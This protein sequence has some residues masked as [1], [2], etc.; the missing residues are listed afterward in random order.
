MLSK[1]S[2]INRVMSDVL[3]TVAF[4][5][6]TSTSLTHTRISHHS[7]LPRRQAYNR[8]V[9]SLFTIASVFADASDSLELLQGIVVGSSRLSHAVYLLALSGV[10]FGILP[11][12]E[13]SRK[14]I[15][16]Q[17]Q[18]KRSIVR[19][20]SNYSYS[21]RIGDVDGL[22]DSWRRIPWHERLKCL[23]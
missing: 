23:G 1:E 11:T 19:W 7:A 20:Y 9:K 14:Y 16:V 10:V 22:L 3:P 5:S 21:E 4:F 2:Y 8:S 12:E 18:Y 17:W 6:I 13:Y 15:F